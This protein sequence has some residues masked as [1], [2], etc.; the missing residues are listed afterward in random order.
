MMKGQGW[1]NY[2]ANLHNNAWG[3]NKIQTKL[4]KCHR[5]I[6]LVHMV[7]DE[8]EKGLQD[9]RKAKDKTSSLSMSNDE[10]KKA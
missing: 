2:L 1:T 10:K 8:E 7:N 9:L 6:L 4:S 5:S 3:K